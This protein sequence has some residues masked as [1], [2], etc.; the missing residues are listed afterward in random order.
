MTCI[1]RLPLAPPPRIPARQPPPQGTFVHL[2]QIPKFTL[3][4]I[5]AM[6]AVLRAGRSCLMR[7]VAGMCRATRN[8]FMRNVA[9]A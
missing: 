1:L 3:N 4:D 8:A 9:V 6:Q 2:D 5:G 7:V